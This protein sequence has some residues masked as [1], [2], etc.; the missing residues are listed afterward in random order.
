MDKQSVAGAFSTGTHG[1][2]KFQILASQASG[3]RFVNGE[4]EIVEVSA[5]DGDVF[6]AAQVSLG[7]LGIVTKYTL[8]LE[9]AYNL[10][11][12]E[13]KEDID[14]VL[15]NLNELRDENRNFE[16]FWFPYTDKA[17]LKKMNE[18][19]EEGESSGMFADVGDSLENF[20]CDKLCRLSSI[21]PPTSKYVSKIGGGSISEQDEVGPYHKIFAHARNVRFNETEYGVPAEKGGDAFG[22]VR[23]YIHSEGIDVCFPI[24]FRFVEGDDILLSPAHGRDTAFIAVHK[25]FR[26][27]YEDYLGRCE[28]IFREHDGRPHWGKMHNL[29][30]KELS[31]LYSEWEKFHG[32]RRRHDPEGVFMNDY[33]KEIFP[34]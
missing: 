34:E 2:G 22:A 21:V 23:D 8:K 10:R 17:I 29:G 26:K 9:P 7:S 24:E 20:A 16:F 27:D 28:E 25:Y 3:V 31:S 6:K 14:Y 15:D 32:I 12:V 4:G 18:T 11:L 5:E 1:T 19:D 30:A 13:E 33:L